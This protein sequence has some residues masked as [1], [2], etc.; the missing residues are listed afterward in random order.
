MAECIAAKVFGLS[1]LICFRGVQERG[2]QFVRSPVIPSK[3]LF[4]SAGGIDHHSTEI[5][6]YGAR[7]IFPKG[8]AELI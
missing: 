6:V 7:F 5:V 4:D 1:V 2:S 3:D 8:L